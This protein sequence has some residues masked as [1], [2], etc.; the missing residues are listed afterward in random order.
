MKHISTIFSLSI[1][2]L[3]FAAAALFPTQPAYACGGY[4]DPNVNADYYYS[5]GANPS[6][7][8]GTMAGAP[9][10]VFNGTTAL[11]TSL[12]TGGDQAVSF[13]GG[14]ADHLTMANHSGVNQLNAVFSNRTYELWFSPASITGKQQ[15]FEHGGITHGGS[16]YLDGNTLYGGVYENEI[17]RVFVSYSGI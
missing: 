12:V 16:I 10:A 14:S 8:G 5:L 2:A 15:L 6:V 11:T 13:A 3:L 4:L 17:T 1:F 7:N 9:N